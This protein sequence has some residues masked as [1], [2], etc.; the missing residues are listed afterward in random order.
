M[1]TTAEPLTIDSD[2]AVARPRLYSR[3]LTSHYIRNNLLLFVANLLTGFGALLLHPVLGHWLS[4]D[5]Y[6]TV[7]SFIALSQI[8]LI[9]T[10]IIAVV[11]SKNTSTLTATDQLAELNDLIRRLTAILLPT[12]IAVTVIFAVASG[13]ISTLAG[14]NSPRGVLI[15][16]IVFTISFAS[17]VNLGALQ[18]LQRFG[19][20]AT[21]SA[22][23]V[24]GRLLFAGTLVI[25]GFGVNGAILG[26]V[27]SYVVAYLVSFLPLRR[28]MTGPRVQFGSLRSLWSYSLTAALALASTNLLYNLD[29]VLAK[30]FL[31]PHEAGL[32]AAL[33][34]TGKIVLFASNSVAA[35]LFPRI[36]TLHT[37]GE[38]STRFV[39][40]ALLSVL[41]ITMSIEIAFI[42]APAPLM[43][44][45]YRSSKF[46][47]A[48]AQLPWYALA[49]LLLALT[50]VLT[51]YFMATGKRPFVF[52]MLASCIVEFGLIVWRHQSI[53]QI[54]RSVALANG[55]LLVV[56]LI[57]F[58]VDAGLTRR[59]DRSSA[60]P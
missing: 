9:P 43:H 35:V 36:A 32:Y 4:V 49:M 42:I 37:R 2:I 22:L 18:G 52:M 11:A 13:N 34:T 19:W 3:L 48:A 44:L 51:A 60:Q 26:L 15:L 40:Y 54:V 57:A 6:G 14:L 47:A 25:L 20:F 1:D 16:A 5:E 27:L 53:E 31:S 24:F 56:L 7:A 30:K 55:V 45:L 46:S 10:Q 38:R 58:A 50:Q 33:A 29:T 8:L 28:L 12:G 41:L 17:P 59:I 23:P 39:L 21:I